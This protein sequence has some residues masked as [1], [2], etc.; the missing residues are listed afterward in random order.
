MV[1]GQTTSAHHKYNPWKNLTHSRASSPDEEGINFNTVKKGL[2]HSY[3]IQVLANLAA[4]FL[5]SM[6]AF[7]GG[8]FPAGAAFFL[9]RQ[10]RHILLNLAILSG[11]FC[12]TFRVSGLTQAALLTVSLIIGNFC[13]RQKILPGRARLK[14]WLEPLSW[15]IGYLVLKISVSQLTPLQVAPLQAE[16]S[17]GVNPVAT[18]LEIAS[19]LV[20]YYFIRLGL[21]ARRQSG[22][23]ADKPGISEGY[24]N[25]SRFAYLF[26][27]AVLLN[28][29]LKLAAQ[30]FY[31]TD[32]GAIWMLLTV[33]YIGGEGVGAMMGIAIAIVLSLSTGGLVTCIGLYG[34]AGFLGGVLKRFGRLGIL[35]GGA[36]GILLIMQQLNFPSNLTPHLIPWGIGMVSFVL[37]P[38]SCFSHLLPYFMP[39]LEMNC[40]HEEGRLRELF[41]SRLHDLAG[42]FQELSKSFQEAA[43]VEQTATRMDLYALLDQVCIK[44]CQQ[45]NGYETC[46]GEN[47]YVTYRELFDLVALAEIYGEVKTEHLKG[48]LAQSCFQQ[49]RLT[50]TVNHLFEKNQADLS[51]QRKLDESKTFL[52]TQL[53]G[54]AGMIES[55]AEEIVTDAS[56]KNEVEDQIRRSFNLIGLPVREVMVMD[57]GAS[58]LEI[59]I[60]QHACSRSRECQ[61]LA[62]PLISGLLGREY[63]VW[64]RRCHQPE[65]FCSYSLVPTRHYT[66][67]T[68]V[69]K[70]AKEGNNSGDS[71]I[72]QELKDGNFVAILSD[73]MG[74]GQKA[75][76]E[77]GTSVSVLEKLLKS[78]ISRDFAV[79]MVNSVLLL[80]SQEESFAT[81]DLA[82]VNLYDGHTEFIKIGAAT[83]YIKRG[84]EVWGI[85]STSLPAGILNMI[86]PE[87]TM[88]HLQPNDFIIM[89]TDGIT[90]SRP[91]A[92]NNEDWL[93]RALQQVEVVGPES[94][95]EYILNMAQH[96]Q[97][98]PPKD[99]MTVVVLQLIER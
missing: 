40:R 80:N 52:T 97:Q 53:Q 15:S 84:R 26:L 49:Y 17:S 72:L 31:L 47:F 46:W 22:S 3:P 2:R 10:P 85:Q 73:G 90:D 60:K 74:H 56:L 27:G 65:G 93:G 23:G 88:L 89:V 19:V 64:E 32:I 33:A 67:R 76:I 59:K 58:K 92:G 18:I 16:L 14:N 82:L 6:A 11:I 44:N 70:I 36:L 21:G 79:K 43:P 63:V 25:A 96:Y 86:N 77:S 71:H 95:S 98:G 62:A 68:A 34:A 61:R 75:A 9:A 28:G 29:S 57:G 30:A 13:A 83:S 4:G 99:D 48:R 8:L 69:G 35:T 66:V 87:K 81:I 1:I 55:L 91:T 50:A 5:Y 94:L 39:P 38:K 24:S 41:L 37:F 20:F 7:P 78:G 51:W 45:C 54:I 12:G 42:I